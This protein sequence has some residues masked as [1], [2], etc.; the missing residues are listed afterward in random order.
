MAGITNFGAYVPLH[1]LAP[2]TDGWAGAS[3]RSVANFDEDSITMAVSAVEDCLRGGDR[4][5][6]DALY[7]ASTTLPYEEKQAA[8]VVLTA[9]DL[10]DDMFTS[11]VSHSI[12]SG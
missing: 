5:G 3:E 10:P 9:S 7:L 1:R 11:D 12:R 2:A 8:T 4:A 6:I